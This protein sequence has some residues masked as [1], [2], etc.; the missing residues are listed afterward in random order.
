[1]ITALA[2]L[3]ACSVLVVVMLGAVS[4][5]G[6]SRAEEPRAP[7]AVEPQAA[8]GLIEFTSK[9]GRFSVRLPAKPVYEKTT[10]GDANEEQ[11]QFLVGREQGAYLVSYQDNPNLAGSGPEGLQRALETGRKILQESFGGELLES[12][13]V[14]LGDATLEDGHPGLSVRI[15]IPDAQG[16][17]RCRLY[18]VG[19]RLYQVMA[20]GVPEFTGSDE[21]AR[22]VDSFKLVP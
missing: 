8:D 2:R 1:M 14:T 13:E 22:I 20:L 10:V 7:G 4:P 6:V 9:E 17:A 12:E 11:H 16:E 19:T 18:L 5:A 15:T 3:A 21:T